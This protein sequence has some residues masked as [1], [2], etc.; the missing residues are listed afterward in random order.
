MALKQ[1]VRSVAGL[2]EIAARTAPKAVGVDFIEAKVLTEQ[3]RVRLGNDMIKLAK[4]R[5]IPGFER[6]GRN[7]LD[8]D[9]VVLIGLMP[10]KGAGLNCGGCGYASCEEFN[11]HS[12]DG[13]FHG[14]NCVL[15]MLD[16]GIALGSAAKVASNMN[17][18]N[19]IMYRV[20]VS[21]KRLGLSKANIVHGIPLSATGKNIFFDR[22]PKK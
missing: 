17:V 18:D 13:D 8:S 21:A 4:E 10:H 5:N 1:T 19:R 12:H 9:A 20:G 15:R 7:V 2:M 22:Q 14:P 6:D 16:M 3:Q 11:K